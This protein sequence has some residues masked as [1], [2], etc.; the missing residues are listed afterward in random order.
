MS[1]AEIV[2][3]VL[4]IFPIVVQLAQW[5]SDAAGKTRDC[6]HYKEGLQSVALDFEIAW[7][8]FR[9]GYRVLGKLYPGFDRAA[10]MARAS[11]NTQP[12]VQMSTD[13]GVNHEIFFKII[14]QISK[15][16]EKFLPI[17]K[18][19]NQKVIFI[20]ILTS[21]YDMLTAYQGAMPSRVWASVNFTLTR[22]GRESELQHIQHLVRSFRRMVKD[23]QVKVDTDRETRNAI[24]KISNASALRRY[25]DDVSRFC[26]IIDQ[27]WGCHCGPHTINMQL[28]E[29]GI[30]L[31]KLTGFHVLCA[32]PF[33]LPEASRE[34]L[35]TGSTTLPYSTSAASKNWQAGEESADID[36][37][38]DRQLSP[39]NPTTFEQLDYR[40]PSLRLRH[41]FGTVTRMIG[42]RLTSSTWLGQNL[43]VRILGSDDHLLISPVARRGS[44]STHET[45]LCETFQR[46]D[47]SVSSNERHLVLKENGISTIFHIS[48]T[49]TIL[50][51]LDSI[52]LFTALSRPWDEGRPLLYESAKLKVGLRISSS[53]IWLIN[54]PNSFPGA[55]NTKS[56]FFYPNI[57]SGSFDADSLLRPY[58]KASPTTNQH[59]RLTMQSALIILG[60]IFVQ[61]LENRILV[62]DYGKPLDGSKSKNLLDRE[63]ISLERY[64][65]M[66]RSI[67]HH[68]FSPHRYQLTELELSEMDF[69]IF[70]QYV[71]AN[72]IQPLQN[73]VTIL[74]ERV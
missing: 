19:L 15:E 16:L 54:S 31:D 20:L 4:G 53:V 68:C 18:A 56:I 24:P 59:G 40:R 7:H 46:W 36:Q 44:L 25:A 10:R 50:Y 14:Q 51:P 49:A 66:W 74:E 64:M 21:N 6:L 27:S 37:G 11:L 62:D 5:G 22:D 42:E 17:F 60:T 61:L 33:K 23:E 67:L 57:E 43:M 29:L 63:D 26:H 41:K 3:L 28:S 69:D 72:I 39:S 1:G 35:S 12:P 58:A 55:A 30:N 71:Y 9:K 38:V 2:G 34:E 8:E 47:K 73:A 13:L 52:S 70:V 32:N 65:P 48:G 45:R